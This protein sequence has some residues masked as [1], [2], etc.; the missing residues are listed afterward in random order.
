MYIY[1]ARYELSSLRTNKIVFFRFSGYKNDYTSTAAAVPQETHGLLGSGNFGVI[2]GGTFY[3]ENDGEAS[4]NYGEYDSYY[5]NGHGKPSFYFDKPASSKQYR[6]QQFA[7]FKD[8]ADINVPNGGQFS[9]YV[10]VYVNKN[11]SEEINPSE[12]NKHFRPNNIMESLA[13]LDLQPSTSTEIIPEKKLSKSK[14]KLAKVLPEKK[15]LV[16]KS[17]KKTSIQEPSE[18]LLALS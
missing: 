12:R 7:N 3:A 2:P 15:W 9:E 14:R 5:Q 10:A 13:L 1:I 16:R 11:S 17:S 6:Q 18:T 4:S 8:F